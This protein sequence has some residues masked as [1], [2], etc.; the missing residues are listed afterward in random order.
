[1][2]VAHASARE[3]GMA[4]L[5]AS[6][7]G[8]R[9]LQGERAAEPTADSARLSATTTSTKPPGLTRPPA[10]GDD[11]LRQRTGCAFS[12]ARRPRL[13]LLLGHQRRCAP[14]PASGLDELPIIS[15]L[16][17]D[18]VQGQAVDGN[19]IQQELAVVHQVLTNALHGPLIL[20]YGRQ[21]H[22]GIPPEPLRCELQRHPVI[23]EG[24]HHDGGVRTELLGHVRQGQAALRHGPEGDVVV[25]SEGRVCV[26]QRQAIVHHRLLDHLLVATEH[27][28]GI[29][30]SPT[31]RADEPHDVTLVALIVAEQGYLVDDLLV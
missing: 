7:G 31:M 13:P 4:D 5:N 18:I 16:L 30:K 19:S 6:E 8:S 12:G 14:A 15:V 2:R 17:P 28:R 26:L 29:A 10:I 20:L 22:L 21:A 9:S 3:R 25:V 11:E 27:D 24:L 1:M 23:E